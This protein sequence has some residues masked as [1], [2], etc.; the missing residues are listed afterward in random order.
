[1]STK[2]VVAVAK[3]YRGFAIFQEAECYSIFTDG[4]AKHEFISQN[5][6]QAFV[7]AF[8]VAAARTMLIGLAPVQ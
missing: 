1:M 8:Y 7:D 3:I 5:E 6:A 4:N 2:T